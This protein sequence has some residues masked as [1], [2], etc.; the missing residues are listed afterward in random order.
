MGCTLN[1][2]RVNLS[3]SLATFFTGLGS[4]VNLG[5]STQKEQMSQRGQT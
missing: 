5:V 3:R 1:I 4:P 2:L